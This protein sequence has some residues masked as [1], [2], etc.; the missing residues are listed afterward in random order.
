VAG[1]AVWVRSLGQD[2]VIVSSPDGHGQV[3]VQIGSFKTR[4]PLADLEGRE[5]ARPE[6]QRY[7]GGSEAVLQAAAVS[8]QL[9]L[10]GYRAE[11]V[12]PALERY[13]NDAYLG[14][15]P[16]VRI[17]HGKGTGVLRQVVRDIL[18]DH[19]LVKE[20]HTADPKEG[21]E[22]ATVAVMAN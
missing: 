5:A 7:S 20:F 12:A 18:D 9:D 15:L 6:I 16:Y 13:L 10:R 21:G 4:L 2:G 11:E 14:S 3:E 1:Q 22:G 17:V 8:L 19:P